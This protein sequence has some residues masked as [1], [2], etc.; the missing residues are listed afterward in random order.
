MKPGHSLR[1][2]ALDGLR[3]IAILLVFFNHVDSGP[4]L[5]V[6]PNFIRP[7]LET[8]F[9]SGPIGVSILFILSGFLMSYIY[10][11]PNSTSTF[12]QKRY[13]RIFPL[14]I[15]MSIVMMVFKIYPTLPIYLR[16][17]TIFSVALIAHFLWV[18]VIQRL[19]KPVIGR[20]IFRMFILLQLIIGFIYVFIIMRHPAINF[21][22]LTSTYLREGMITAVNATL[23]LPL[24]NYIPMLD[25]VYW[26]LTAGVLFY[27][28]YPI[29]FVP[30]I[31]TVIK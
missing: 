4:I 14:F 21:N 30:F 25:G 3:G 19:H 18:Y 16:I 20:F 23:T 1:L 12:L 11:H 9:S 15:T 5:S 17:A 24:G 22:Q 8:I 6:F 2:L 26:S 29:I 31:D 27:I 28:L 7:I 13:T 10:P